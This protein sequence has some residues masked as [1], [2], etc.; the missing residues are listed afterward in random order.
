[1][2]TAFRAIVKQSSKGIFEERAKIVSAKGKFDQ[3]NTSAYQGLSDLMKDLYWQAISHFGADEIASGIQKI[4]TMLV[5]VLVEQLLPELE[6]F[7]SSKRNIHELPPMESR[8]R[9][10]NA[11]CEFFQCIASLYEHPMMILLDDI[12]WA[13]DTSMF[14]IKSLIKNTKALFVF[15]FRVDISNRNIP[16]QLLREEVENTPEYTCFISLKGL[17]LEDVQDLTADMMGCKANTIE[18][19]AL[20]LHSKTKGNPLFLTKVS[21]AVVL[22]S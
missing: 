18:D 3:L 22:L 20:V 4:D 17:S 1:M 6:G 21:I 5:Q 2:N 14:L 12:Q 11:I 15:C 16:I 7:I 10:E 13:S 8:N 9:L 19:L